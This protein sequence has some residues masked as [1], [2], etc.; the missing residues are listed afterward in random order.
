MHAD[1]LKM[2]G[3]TN[4]SLI[5]R[6]FGSGLINHTWKVDYDNAEYILQRINNDVF[7][8]PQDIESNIGLLNEYLKAHH[9]EYFFVAP[10]K[11]LDGSEM[12]YLPQEGYFRMFP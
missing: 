7:Q 12:V 10:V 11:A 5:M 4:D 9:P 1:I 3:F 2:Y 6:A 8:Q